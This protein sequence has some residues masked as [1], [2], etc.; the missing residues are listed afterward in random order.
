MIKLGEGD[1]CLWRLG[2][3]YRKREEPSVSLHSIIFD[4]IQLFDGH[5]LV[6][7]ASKSFWHANPSALVR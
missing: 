6:K 3:L 4:P 7:C 2:K 5:L 1:F